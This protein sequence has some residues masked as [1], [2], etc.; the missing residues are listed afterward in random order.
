MGVMNMREVVIVSV[1]RIV[2]GSFGG[3]FKLVLVVELGVIVVKEVIKRV[4]IILDMIDEFFLGG[5]FIVG[6]G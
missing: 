5:V 1:V 3:V 4:N 2:V 6:F